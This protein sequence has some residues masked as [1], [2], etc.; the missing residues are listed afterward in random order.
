MSIYGELINESN[1]KDSIKSNIIREMMHILKFKY[2]SNRQSVSWINSIF[3]SSKNLNI[4]CQQKSIHFIYDNN[5]L[6]KLYLKALRK[7][8]H[9]TGINISKFQP[10]RPIEFTI[11]NLTNKEW[12]YNYLYPLAYSDEVRKMLDIAIKNK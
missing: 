2:Q 10:T 12:I 1:V 7:A 8:S 9:E 5:E 11:E 4:L 3:D 6:D